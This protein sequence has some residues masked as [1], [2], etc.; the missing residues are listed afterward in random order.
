MS[1]RVVF[2]GSAGSSE[3]NSMVGIVIIELEKELTAGEFEGA[4]VMLRVGIV[5]GG[6]FRERRHAPDHHCLY[7]RGQGIDAG[8]HHHAPAGHRGTE[9]VVE[10]PDLRGAHQM[11]PASTSAEA[12]VF[13]PQASHQP[14]SWSGSI[15][16][17]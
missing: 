1:T 7:V 2:A 16:A 14:R 10:L 11:I 6:E 5:V 17:V 3:P 13:V 4:E 9:R 15:S 8:G 12:T